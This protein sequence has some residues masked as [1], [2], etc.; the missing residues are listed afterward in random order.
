MK[1]KDLKTICHSELVS[2][3]HN[4]SKYTPEGALDNIKK[5]AIYRTLDNWHYVLKGSFGNKIAGQIDYLR[6]YTDVKI[7][8]ITPEQFEVIK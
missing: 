8:V 2:E 4:E 6:N 1:T 5:H 7:E 3:S